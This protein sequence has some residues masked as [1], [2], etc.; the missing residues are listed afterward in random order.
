VIKQKIIALV[1]RIDLRSTLRNY[2]LL[3][4]GAVILAINFDIFLASAQV[5]IPVGK[6]VPSLSK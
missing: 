2:L 3:T 1:S 5:S 6:V 4:I